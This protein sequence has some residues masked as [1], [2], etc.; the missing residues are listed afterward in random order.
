MIGKWIYQ[1]IEEMPLGEPFSAT[2]FLDLGTRKSVSRVLARLAKTDLIMRVTRGIYC[3]PMISEFLGPVHPRM[4]KLLDYV[5][6]GEVYQVHGAEA[7]RRM[8]LSTQVPMSRVFVTSG[9]SR[10]GADGKL[11]HPAD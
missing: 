4:G 3:R 10:V 2:E 9:P 11:T 1:R 7:A 5:M 6:R 8:E